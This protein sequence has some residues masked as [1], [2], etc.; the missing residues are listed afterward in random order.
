M[1]RL[2]ESHQRR[3]IN[4]FV[5]DAHLC[6]DWRKHQICTCKLV[7]FGFTT[8]WLDSIWLAHHSKQRPGFKVG[9]ACIVVAICLFINL[10]SSLIRVVFFIRRDPFNFLSNWIPNKLLA[11]LWYS[12]DQ[13]RRGQFKQT[14]INWS[15]Y[16]I[17]IL[18][19]IKRGRANEIISLACGV[20]W[21]YRQ[22]CFRYRRA[23]VGI[24]S[25]GRKMYNLS[26][27]LLHKYTRATFFISFSQMTQIGMWCEKKKY[28][29]ESE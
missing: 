7:W 9:K 16:V 5:L 19:L 21:K 6:H 17:E 12:C 29:R 8:V 14:Q 18:P 28:E 27:H 11:D 3:A 22:R 2:I 23:V 13:T 1:I 15:V 20:I 24:H 25:V 10:G 26:S 4:N